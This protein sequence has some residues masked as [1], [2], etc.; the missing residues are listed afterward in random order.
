MAQ[1]FLRRFRHEV[2]SC[3]QDRSET[4]LQ[5]CG[6]ILSDIVDWEPPLQR[7]QTMTSCLPLK[8]NLCAQSVAIKSTLGDFC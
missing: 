3:P 8:F 4:D 5:K 7:I 1:L 2:L 6:Q